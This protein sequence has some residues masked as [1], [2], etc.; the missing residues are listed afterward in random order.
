MIPGT[1]LLELFVR[2]SQTALYKHSILGAIGYILP[3]PGAAP[4]PPAFPAMMEISTD[5]IFSGG[6][7]DISASRMKWLRYPDPERGVFADHVMRVDLLNG[8]WFLE[9]QIVKHFLA[10]VCGVVSCC[11]CS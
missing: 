8:L 9:A 7:G 11:L 1:S 4:P 6:E 5:D 2:T 10:E 3:L